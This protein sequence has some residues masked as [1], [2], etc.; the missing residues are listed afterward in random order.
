[1]SK[2]RYE[3]EGDL[4]SS[5]YAS[6]RKNHNHSITSGIAVAPDPSS[7]PQKYVSVSIRAGG[8]RG[9]IA[10]RTVGRAM[11]YDGGQKLSQKKVKLCV[12]V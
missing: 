5:A 7:T 12:G 10:V 11:C 2:A 8:P 1:M 3:L 9:C 4:S 6:V